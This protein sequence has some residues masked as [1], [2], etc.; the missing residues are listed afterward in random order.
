MTSDG[1]AFFAE[2][3]DA[4]FQAW[5]DACNAGTHCAGAASAW[6]GY[7][8]AVTTD[9]CLKAQKSGAIEEVPLSER[10]DFYKD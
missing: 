10:P 4:E 1:L 3:Y 5:A 6:D 2:A 8:A 7:C 9:S